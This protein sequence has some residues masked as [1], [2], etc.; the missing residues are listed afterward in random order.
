MQK[1][2]TD[3]LIDFS[4]NAFE[5]NTRRAAF[6]AL[7]EL[8]VF[9]EVV[10]EHAY[11]AALSANGRLSNGGVGYLNWAY[12]NGEISKNAILTKEPQ[13]RVNVDWQ[14]EVWKKI[15]APKK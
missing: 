2:S 9:N 11:N 7:R 4:S 3:E 6:A 13:W 15:K 14:D 8:N 1:Q 10:S 5:F 12:N